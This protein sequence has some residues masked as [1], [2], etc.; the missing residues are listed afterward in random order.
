LSEI[1]P[2]K[3][4]VIQYSDFRRGGLRT[5]LRARRRIAAIG[6]I[7]KTGNRPL[8]PEYN[9]PTG[10]GACPYRPCISGCCSQ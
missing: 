8:L 9:V 10:G 3:D 7:V 5:K 2:L 6:N 1:L 4:V